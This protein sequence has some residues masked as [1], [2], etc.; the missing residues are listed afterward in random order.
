MS[1]KPVLTKIYIKN[2]EVPNEVTKLLYDNHVRHAL[3][4]K[5]RKLKITHNRVIPYV[6]R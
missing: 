2:L 4:A 3:K 6:S 1:K 5:S